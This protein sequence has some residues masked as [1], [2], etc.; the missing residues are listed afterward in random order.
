MRSSIVTA[1]VLCIL[2]FAVPGSAEI[3]AND[4]TPFTATVFVSCANGG[5]GEPVDLTGYLHVLL[6]STVN[7]NNVSGKYHFQ[8][9]GVSGVG[10]IT[11]DKYQ[12]T[13]VSQE[14][15]AGSLTNSHY[16][17]TF[18]NNFRIIGQGPGNNFLVHENMHITISADGTVIVNHD[19]FSATCK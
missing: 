9:M 6:S 13:G 11:G 1:V 18:V 4:V 10:Q 14:S 19:N 15:F 16:T 7:E 12:A 3:T 17:D 5:K 2:A 8:P